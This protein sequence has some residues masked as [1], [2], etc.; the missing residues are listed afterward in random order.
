ML[1]TIEWLKTRKPLPPYEWCD[2]L[3][4]PAEALICDYAKNGGTGHTM[5]DGTTYG[6]RCNMFGGPNTGGGECGTYG[7]TNTM[8]VVLSWLYSDSHRY[9]LYADD[10]SYAAFAIGP[11]PEH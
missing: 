8:D 6:D 3:T 9:G 5:T 1:E 10:C 2:D 7:D 11:H 4:V